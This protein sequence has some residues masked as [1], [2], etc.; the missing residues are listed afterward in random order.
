MRS[1]EFGDAAPTAKTTKNAPLRQT[2]ATLAATL[3]TIS[4]VTLIFA[5]ILYKQ[6]SPRAVQASKWLATLALYMGAVVVLLGV[7]AL[8]KGQKQGYAAEETEKAEE[9]EA[10]Q[11]AVPSNKVLYEEVQSG[12][13]LENNP[14]FNDS[15]L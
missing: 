14:E 2:E 3:L 4:G 13:I 6:G 10:P 12:D 7:M 8:A 11:K 1:D 15:G 9:T 5:G